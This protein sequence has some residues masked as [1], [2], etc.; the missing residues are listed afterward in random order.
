MAALRLMR[1]ALLL[2]PAVSKLF[3]LQVKAVLEM[4]GIRVMRHRDY[5]LR[6]AAEAAAEAAQYMTGMTRVS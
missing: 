2:F 4:Q 6:V 1:Q 3:R 5:L